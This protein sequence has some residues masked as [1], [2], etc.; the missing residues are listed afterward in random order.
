MLHQFNEFTG[1][2]TRG[3]GPDG[4]IYADSYSV[5]LSDD[6]EPVSLTAPGFRGDQGGWGF[7]YLNLTRA[8]IDVYNGTAD[9]VTLMAV[10]PPHIIAD[11][12]S[13]HWTTVGV[14][15]E[16]YTL[17]IDGTVVADSVSGTGISLPIDG[18]AT[19]AH[20]LSVTA[21]GVG[22]RYA[23]SPY[24]FDTPTK[25]LQPVTVEKTLVIP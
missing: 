6:Y 23:L 4:N 16:S 20:T 15:P 10:A 2:A 22:T 18:L 19:G 9:D 8:L 1:Q 25:E 14:E 13:V 17:S 5:E 11:K 3:Y 12:V 24:E 7:Y 21:N